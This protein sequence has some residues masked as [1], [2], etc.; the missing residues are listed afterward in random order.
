MKSMKYSTLV[1]IFVVSFILSVSLTYSAQLNQPILPKT[2]IPAKRTTPTE[3]KQIPQDIKQM[4]APPIIIT[5][6]T[7]ADVLY[8]DKTYPLTW[9]RSGKGETVKYVIIK[10]VLASNPLATSPQCPDN[11]DEVVKNTGSFM[12]KLNKC[13]ELKSKLFGTPCTDASTGMC[14]FIQVEDPNKEYIINIDGWGGCGTECSDKVK[15]KIL[16]Q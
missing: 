9:K 13:G 8:F 11:T 7:T 5:S 12:L 14:K 4:N 3:I 6:P 16:N 10:V 15:V 1:C 2:T